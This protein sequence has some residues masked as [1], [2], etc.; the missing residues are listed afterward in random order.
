MIGD[1]V[2]VRGAFSEA[3]TSCIYDDNE[4]VEAIVRNATTVMCPSSNAKRVQVGTS[5]EA[6][7]DSIL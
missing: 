4:V 2:V 1:E 3:V 5:S 7:S 6:L